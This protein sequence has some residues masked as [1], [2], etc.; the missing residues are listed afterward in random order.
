M[1]FPKTMS[2]SQT[3]IFPPCFLAK[4]VYFWAAGG[5][6]RI[7][8]GGRVTGGMKSPT[9]VLGVESTWLS[10]LRIEHPTDR[11]IKQLLCN[12]GEGDTVS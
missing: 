3:M 8:A 1:V 11:S 2:T 7:P 9:V 4:C 6:I 5:G 10:A 12:C